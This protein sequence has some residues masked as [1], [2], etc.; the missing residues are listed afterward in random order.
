MARIAGGVECELNIVIDSRTQ[1]AITF[2]A[3]NYAIE[4]MCIET[5]RK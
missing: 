2:I 5:N 4:K 3:S 1:L